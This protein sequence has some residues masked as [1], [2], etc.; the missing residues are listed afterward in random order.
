MLKNRNP[1]IPCPHL[2][3]YHRNNPW[4]RAMTPPPELSL[5]TSGSGLIAAPKGTTRAFSVAAGVHKATPGEHV[6][7]SFAITP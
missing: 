5:P 6:S 2:H 1:R 7:E 4:T 3:G